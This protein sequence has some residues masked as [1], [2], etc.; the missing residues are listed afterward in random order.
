[1]DRKAQL[2]KFLLFIKRAKPCHIRNRNF[3]FKGP[4]YREVNKVDIEHKKDCLR[5]YRVIKYSLKQK[6]DELED[7][8]DLVNR[9]TFFIS[10]EGFSPK[11][12]GNTKEN[13]VVKLLQAK[14]AL[15]QEIQDLI[16]AKQEIENAIESV[17][18]ENLKVVLRFIYLNGKPV[19]KIAGSMDYTVRNIQYMHRKALEMV[20]MEDDEHAGENKKE[21]PGY[22]S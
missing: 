9:I 8:K 14:E 4:V 18:D 7:L 16:E 22:N 19:E 11:T 12:Q 20:R 2:K 10:D 5:K 1:L 15:N 21:I 3:S 6:L 13:N 17:E